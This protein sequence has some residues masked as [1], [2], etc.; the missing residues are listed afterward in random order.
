[1]NKS[2]IL[3][4]HMLFKRLRYFIWRIGFLASFTLPSLQVAAE[5][6]SIVFPVIGGATFRNDF[7]DP[8]SGGRTH[9]GNDIF[10]KKMHPL[11]AVADGIVRFTSYPEPNYGYIISIEDAD[12]Y[13]YWYLHVNNDAPGTDDGH[14]GGMFAYATDIVH[15]NP[16]RAGQLIGWMGDSGN[17]EST[18][19]HLHF[20]IHRPDGEVINPYPT[21]QGARKINSPVVGPTIPDEILPFGQSTIGSSIAYGDVDQS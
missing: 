21:L 4:I 18:P 13:Q 8:R 20:E 11:V 17:A 1:M 15:G 2:A 7:G 5:T 9:K 19:P 14:G 3:Q 16:G 12:G 6:H 10:G